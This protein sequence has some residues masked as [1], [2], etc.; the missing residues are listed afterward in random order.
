MASEHERQ[1]SL[2]HCI[3]HQF[4]V[5]SEQAEVLVADESIARSGRVRSRLDM[6]GI[7]KGKGW[8]GGMRRYEWNGGK[9]REGKGK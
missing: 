5:A 6:D 7:K 8:K 1:R 2:R 3:G 9:G 4:A